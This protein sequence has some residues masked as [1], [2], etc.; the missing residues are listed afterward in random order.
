MKCPL[1]NKEADM[2]L[3]KKINSASMLFCPHCHGN[4]MY[5]IPTDEDIIHQYSKQYYLNMG[6]IE[7]VCY[8]KMKTFND[9][10]KRISLYKRK[11]TLLDIGT[12]YGFFIKTALE[13]GFDSYGIDISEYAISVAKQ[14]ISKERFFVESILNTHF[15]NEYFDVITLIDVFEHVNNPR[16]VLDKIYSLLK[17]DGILFLVTPNSN[18]L[19]NLLQNINMK[20]YNL[21][22]IYRYNANILNQLFTDSKFKIIE[23]KK[24]LKT[25]NISFINSHFTVFKLF[26]ITC[27]FNFLNKFKFLNKISFKLSLGNSMFLLK[28]I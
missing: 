11:G 27:I 25:V 5:P 10:I 16:L 20:K 3:K 26:P 12:A 1:C 7:N 2:K 23:T 21:E 17:K 15:K 6:D 18:S 4:F 14:N 9:Y 22:H 19:G 28:K 8:V 13:F 24:V